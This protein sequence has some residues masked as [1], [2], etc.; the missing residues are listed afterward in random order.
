M[1]SDRAYFFDQGLRFECRRCGQCC[2][3]APGT[4][5]VS[6]DEI[7]PM[8]DHLGMAVEPFIESYLYPYKDSFSIAEDPH[9]NCLFFNQGCTIY[10]ARPLQCRTFPFWLSILRSKKRWREIQRECPGIGQGRL[11]SRQEIL[12]QVHRAMAF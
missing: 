7:A 2:T 6:P 8:A 4:V 10:T 3:G 1:F 11:Y 9:G 12:A 5:F